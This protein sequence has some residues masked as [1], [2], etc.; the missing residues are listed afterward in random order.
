M[1]GDRID[2]T[3]GLGWTGGVR[4]LVIGRAQLQRQLAL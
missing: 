4:I 1:G 3:R 2:A